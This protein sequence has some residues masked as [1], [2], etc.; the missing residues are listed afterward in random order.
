MRARRVGILTINDPRRGLWRD[1]EALLWA[2]R[3]P[4]RRHGGR[5]PALVS[6]FPLAS[7][8]VD[9]SP[10]RVHAARVKVPTSEAVAPGTRLTSWLSQLDVLVVDEKLLPRLFAMARRKGVEVVY[11]VDLDWATAKGGPG[12]WLE[13]V[14]ASGCRVWAKT[15]QAERT[16]EGLGLRPQLVEWSIP[17]RVRRDR[18]A[19]ERAPRFLMNAGLGGWRNRRGVDIALEA[20]RRARR[21]VGGIRLRLKSIKPLASY[22]EPALLATPGLETIEGFCDRQELTALYGE[23]DVVLY[24]S[25][26]EGFGL[27]LLEALHHGLPAVATDGWPM[28]EL[29]EDGH[30]GLLVAAERRADMRLAARWECRPE[31]MAE[32]MVRLA[33]D[34]RL[35]AR[36][37]CPEPSELVARQHRFVVRVRELLLAEPAPRVV[38]FRARSEP[39]WRRSEEYWADALEAHGYRVERA[40]V[41]ASR[42]ELRRLLRRH[43]DFVLVSKAPPD[44]LRKVRS[45]SH[46]PIVLWHHDQCSLYPDWMR[47]VAPLVDLM[48]VPESQLE[49]RF[50]GLG[51]RHVT[52]MPGAKVDGDRG[53]GRRPRLAPQREQGP[54]VVFLGNGRSLGRRASYLRGLA[55]DLEVHVH[56]RRWRRSRYRVRPEVWGA[57]AARVHREAKVVLS[58][59]NA[60]TIPHYTSNRLFNSCGAGACV[61][62]EMYPGLDDHYPPEAVARF[63]GESD[64][65][66]VVRGLVRDAG[67]RRRR[68]ALAE[69]HTWRHHT[70]ADRVGE[71]LTAVQGLAPEAPAVCAERDFW[72]RRARQK[73]PRA[74]GYHRWSE[75]RFEHETES[76]WQRLEPHAGPARSEGRVRCL[77]FGC[78]AGRFA[79]RLARAGFDTV[80]VDI[81]AE[82]LKLS[83][84]SGPA[85]HRSLLISGD[86]RLPFESASFELVW[87]C[88]VLQHVPDELLSRVTAELLRVAGDGAVLVL[89][90]NTAAGKGRTSS[91]GHVIFR[92]P[93]EYLDLFRGV[94]VQDEFEQHG[95][96]HTVFAGELRTV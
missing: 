80:G 87:I 69:T 50:P 9:G 65:A 27:S 24:P 26:W 60:A 81:S 61:A 25:R 45:L 79:V 38:L 52:L 89:C 57:E 18:D 15:P 56:G 2:L 85:G 43:H 92:D 17:D 63:S 76:L 29:V 39:A 86:G 36:L 94:A 68:R 82:L 73:G 51:C 71:L 53:P 19:R 11:L 93:A 84:A 16:L 47:S 7:W 31:T 75:S 12:G 48:C 40:F 96:R 55:R 49:R 13:A 95:E 4:P 58:I 37:T 74:V 88:T 44:L 33:T 23:A 21:E 77:D 54:D 64:C 46:R 83:A 1:A 70:W 62:A 6:L 90:E 78:G 42:E 59:S 30:N 41:Q 10:E 3:E 28:N 34:E 20:F 22:V 5:R 72:D 66:Q 35:R 8:R 91:S 14:R 67:E 32:A